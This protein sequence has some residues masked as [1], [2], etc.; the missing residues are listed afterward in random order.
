[1]HNLRFVVRLSIGALS[2]EEVT[3]QPI[4]SCCYRLTVLG[5]GLI[6]KIEYRAGAVLTLVSPSIALTWRCTQK[7]SALRRGDVPLV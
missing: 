5:T 4:V 3:A 6:D 1:M 7:S 2:V